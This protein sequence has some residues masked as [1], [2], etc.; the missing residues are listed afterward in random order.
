LAEQAF[1]TIK[2]VYEK[3][4]SQYTNMV[5]PITDG[6]KNFYVHI[7]LQK[8][9]ETQG[10]ELSRTLTKTIMLFM[11][12]ENW[13]EHLREMDDLKQ[14]VHNA[15][16][17][18]KDPLLIYKLE[19]YELF[20]AM[21]EKIN[22]EVISMLIK[23]QI[24]LRENAPLR[25]APQQRTDLSRLQTGR[26][27]LAAS[28]ENNAPQKTAPVRVEKQVGRNE[29]CPCGSGKKFKQCHGKLM[30]E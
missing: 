23:A 3:Q 11:I 6:F 5:V 16:Y 26:Q 9:Y 24:P 4:A 8:A 15:A 2:N 1:P 27:E 17:E 30:Q 12:D 18:Q 29:L 19:S 25:E 10:A 20:S 28:G 21:L 22:R 13:R 7:N 14:A